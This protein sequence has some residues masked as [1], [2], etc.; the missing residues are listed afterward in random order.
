M[1]NNVGMVDRGARVVVGI[2]LIL[3]A[4]MSSSAYAWIG[5][6]GVLPLIT[7]LMGWCPAYTL[8]GLSTCPRRSD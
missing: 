2:V 6:I 7:G 3:F 4:L 1:S 5:W 8:V